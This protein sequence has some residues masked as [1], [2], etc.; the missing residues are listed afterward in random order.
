M[1][2]TILTISPEVNSCRP[3]GKSCFGAFCK[4]CVR[5]IVPCSF[6]HVQLF[7]LREYRF[8]KQPMD[9]SLRN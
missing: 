7:I 5:R 2:K 9:N 4:L 6:F 8:W 3:Q 1:K